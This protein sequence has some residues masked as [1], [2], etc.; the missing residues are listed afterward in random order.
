MLKVFLTRVEK[1][2]GVWLS[3]PTTPADIGVAYATLDNINGTDNLDTR[4]TGVESSIRNLRQYLI[5]KSTDDPNTIKELDFIARRIDGFTETEAVL[6]SGALDIESINTLADI[7]NLTYSLEGYELYPDVTTAKELGQYLVES[8]EVQIHESALP[9]VDYE[10]VATE[11]EAKN[12]GTYTAAGYVAKT[13]GSMERI[14]DGITLPD[15][16]ADK[17]Y[18]FKLKLISQYSFDRLEDPYT[19]KLPTSDIALRQARDQLR[20]KHFDEC[21]IA[22]FDRPIANLSDRLHMDGDIYSLNKL[23]QKIKDML[24]NEGM[25]TKLLAALEAEMPEDLCNTLDIAEDLDRY[26]LIPASVINAT[27]YAHHVLFESGRYDI[28]VD[29]EINSFVD[30]E[31][32]GNYKM[33]EDGV[34]QTAF[35]MIR[36]IDE[37]FQEQEQGFTQKMGGM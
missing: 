21:E 5:G 12:S 2:N 7:I 10:R 19:L 8:G 22:D 1:E 15:V 18:I 25:I 30:Y 9:Y 16:N 6:F 11:Y 4:L 35:G 27:D 31:K 20:V 32:Y 3:L 17:D 34:K 37:P 23:A 24:P 13:G 36:R 14:Y 29:D 28:F 26:E 33:I